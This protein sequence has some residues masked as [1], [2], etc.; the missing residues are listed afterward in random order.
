MQ[1][2]IARGCSLTAAMILPHF[3]VSNF[4][5]EECNNMPVDVSWSIHDNKMKTK[6]L[7]PIKNNFPSIKSMTFDN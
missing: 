6:T 1:R 7:F 3:H 2:T 4:Q 5:I